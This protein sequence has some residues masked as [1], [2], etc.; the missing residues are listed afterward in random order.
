M[1]GARPPTSHPMLSTGK[2]AAL[3]RS[4]GGGQRQPHGETTPPDDVRKVKPRTG[5][6][7]QGCRGP[8]GRGLVR[9]KRLSAAVSLP[10]RW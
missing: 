3:M 7:L 6:E 8:G 1:P 4:G 9:V 2:R 5:C 10:R